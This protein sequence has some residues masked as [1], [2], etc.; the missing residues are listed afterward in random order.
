MP[1]KQIAGRLH[2]WRKSS[3]SDMQGDQCVEVACNGRSGLRVTFV[4]EVISMNWLVLLTRDWWRTV[5]AALRDTA[6]TVRLI[7]ILL[8]VSLI[9]SGLVVL[10]LISYIVGHMI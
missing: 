5:R 1:E 7:A 10:G 8:T 3:Y 6:Q 9:I 4:K 2:A